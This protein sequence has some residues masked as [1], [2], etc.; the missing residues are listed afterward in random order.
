MLASPNSNMTFSFT[1]VSIIVITTLKSLNRMGA[2]VKGNEVLEFKKATQSIFGLKNN[3]YIA[4]W[5]L[6]ADL[7]KHFI[8]FK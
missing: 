7:Y 2:K 8:K 4:L 3:F 5:Y 1:K 6:L